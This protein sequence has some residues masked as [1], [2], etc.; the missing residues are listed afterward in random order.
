VS[1]LKEFLLALNFRRG[2]GGNERLH[3]GVFVHDGDIPECAHVPVRGPLDEPAVSS[4]TEIATAE[5]EDQHPSVD[6]E[7]ERLKVSSLQIAP[8]HE[9]KH[10]DVDGPNEDAGAE[11]AP[12]EEAE[13]DPIEKPVEERDREKN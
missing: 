1:D 2:N 13:E 7:A 9:G 5:A 4:E 10:D 6:D 11:V 3:I 8:E 12:E